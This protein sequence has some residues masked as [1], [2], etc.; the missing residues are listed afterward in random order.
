MGGSSGSAEINGLIQESLP[1]LVKVFFVVHQR[2]E[3]AGASESA[4]SAEPDRTLPPPQSRYR[5]FAFI[6][7]E[8]PDVIAACDLVICRGGAGTLW[9]CAALNKPMIIIPLRRGS[10]GDQVENAKIFEK[11]GAAVNLCDPSKEKILALA[12]S[13]AADKV[14]RD[15]MSG[16]GVTG[17]ADLIADKII[18][19]VRK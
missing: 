18:G 14:K 16:I 5:P 8:M 9:E 15:A 4:K 6:H 10:R 3:I 11:A 17:A 7:N 12:L 2:G 19:R 13:L 1:E